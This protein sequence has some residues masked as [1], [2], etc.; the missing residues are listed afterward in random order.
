MIFPSPRNPDLIK[1]PGKSSADR[2][3][4]ILPPLPRNK[5]RRR[6]RGNESTDRR[7]IIEIVPGEDP[8]GDCNEWDG[9]IDEVRGLE[10]RRE[11]AIIRTVFYNILHYLRKLETL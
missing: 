1:L 3:E 8:E 6:R 2:G 5:R 11:P 4:F 7:K 10:F 9:D